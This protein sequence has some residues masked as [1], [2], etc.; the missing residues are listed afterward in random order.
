MTVLKTETETE[1]AVF[2]VIPTE[3][4]RVL[5]IQ[6]RY[7]TKPRYCYG[8]KLQLLVLIRSAVLSLVVEILVLFTWCQPAIPR[9]R[10]SEGPQFSAISNSDNLRIARDTVRGVTGLGS[11]VWLRQYQELFPA[12]T[13]NDGFQNG[14]PFGMADRNCLQHCSGCLT[15]THQTLSKK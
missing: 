12:M 11:V 3:T 10:H 15:D 13:M 6:N 9:G 2:P 4:D 7:N 8:L 5:T 14:G 1:T